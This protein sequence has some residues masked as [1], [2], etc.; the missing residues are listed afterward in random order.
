MIIFF[1]ISIGTIIYQNGFYPYAEYWKRMNKIISGEDFDLTM[2]TIST[3]QLKTEKLIF[4]GK[5]NSHFFQSFKDYL[6]IEFNGDTI[7]VGDTFIVANDFVFH[8]EFKDGMGR[9]I[10]LIAINDAEAIT[11]VGSLYGY[12][13]TVSRKRDGMMYQK[14]LTLLGKWFYEKDKPLGIAEIK[15]NNQ[16]P[17]LFDTLWS[18]HF[19][20]YF[21]ENLLFPHEAKKIIKLLEIMYECFSKEYEIYLPETIFVYFYGDSLCPGEFNC[22]SNPF[23]T[24]WLKFQGRKSLLMPQKGSP[25]YTLAHE[26]ARISLQP[27]SNEYPPA[28]G[29]DD[30]SHY[31]PLCGIVPY[32]YEKL[33]DSAW[34]ANYDYQSYGIPLFEKIYQGGENTYAWLLYEIDKKYGKKMIGDA[35][36][37]V[38]RDKYWR[39]PEMKSFM[40]TLVKMTSDRNLIARMDKAYPTPFEHSL[41][42]WKRWRDFGF[43]PTLEDMFIFKSI[44]I[45]DSVI[46]GSSADSLG[47]YQGDEI[48]LIDNF[49]LKTH[50][51][52]AYKNLLYKNKGDKIIFAIKSKKLRELK[53]VIITIN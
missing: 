18:K 51:A 36:K 29:A 20:L 31:A 39:H 46:S 26:M 17:R 9:N 11:G 25:I 48:V 3:E 22:Y 40:D 28:I 33:K 45:I 37:S 52:D 23:N 44:F 7:F 41:S 10:E 43:R 19:K 38:V 15:W 49:N 16:P 14:D 2:D 53:K 30:W 32:V 13:F 8:C 4:L 24:I 6:P 35:I 12:D 1:L 50:K 47:F 5:H 42:K 21:G 34:I 27:L